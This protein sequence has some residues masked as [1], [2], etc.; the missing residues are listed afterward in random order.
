MIFPYE[1]EDDYDSYPLLG[2]VAEGRTVLPKLEDLYLESLKDPEVAKYNARRAERQLRLPQ[3]TPYGPMQHDKQGEQ[4]LNLNPHGREEGGYLVRIRNPVY[5]PY[6]PGE[7]PAANS[8][9]SLAAISRLS[10][11]NLPAETEQETE[12]QKRRALLK[13]DEQLKFNRK[14]R[15]IFE[16]VI[17]H[18]GPNIAAPPTAYEFIFATQFFTSNKLEAEK[19]MSAHEKDAEENER[20]DLFRYY[21]EA[22][23][24]VANA[25]RDISIHSSMEMEELRVFRDKINKSDENMVK[26]LFDDVL[27]PSCLKYMN[28][29]TK[30][31]DSLDKYSEALKNLEVYKSLMFYKSTENKTL[32]Q[33][34]VVWD[35]IQTIQKTNAKAR[36]ELSKAKSDIERASMTRDRLKASTTRVIE[37]MPKYEANIVA[38]KEFAV[39]I[40]NSLTEEEETRARLQAEVVKYQTEYGQNNRKLLAAG[41]ATHTPDQSLEPQIRQL[42]EDLETNNAALNEQINRVAME[43]K[44]YSTGIAKKKEFIA[45][46]EVSLKELD[47][48]NKQLKSQKVAKEVFWLQSNNEK[49]DAKNAVV[50]KLTEAARKK[51][52][53]VIKHFK[54]LLDELNCTGT[55]KWISENDETYERITNLYHDKL[56]TLG[57]KLEAFKSSNQAKKTISEIVC[58]AV[59]ELDKYDK[60]IDSERSLYAQKRADCADLCDKLK[61][62]K[63]SCGE[64]QK[65]YNEAGI[66]IKERE[67]FTVFAKNAIQSASKSN[68][69]IISAG[70]NRCS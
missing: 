8:D 36:E 60:Q 45:K 3:S 33:D 51:T 39:N 9:D 55:P 42:K 21:R 4:F 2:N 28:T 56:I 50:E 46:T 5:G 63:I 58:S 47:V 52:S 18:I 1:K 27:K 22:R 19:W 38:L 62:A 61:K 24:T 13:Y 57:A 43:T 14:L 53:A 25:V 48:S 68:D 20:V 44:T 26:A 49:D 30:H 10:L 29:L 70:Q 35:E 40:K 67:R 17:D 6:Q 23:S 37:T 69:K 54:G 41:K 31:I 11:A 65:M 64:L 16:D 15:S 59:Q 7:V 66:Q 12:M 32:F 34:D